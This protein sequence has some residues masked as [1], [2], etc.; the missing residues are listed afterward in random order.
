MKHDITSPLMPVRFGPPPERALRYMDGLGAAMDVLRHTQ[1]HAKYPVGMLVRVLMDAMQH[2]RMH[3][4]LTE[5]DRPM[6]LAVW[7]TVGIDMHQAWL[8]SPPSLADILLAPAMDDR[9]DAKG[10]LWLPL[11][12][13]PFGGPLHLIEHLRSRLPGATHAWALAPEQAVARPVW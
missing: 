8:A 2:G 7:R 9:P 13:T 12:L 4:A 6:G 1:W 10:Y 5:A 3:L 11:L